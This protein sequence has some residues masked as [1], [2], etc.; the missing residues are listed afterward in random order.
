MLRVIDCCKKT[1]HFVP[2]L[3]PD[4]CTVFLWTTHLFS[5][6]GKISESSICLL[7]PKN[8]EKCYDCVV[9]VFLSTSGFRNINKCRHYSCALDSLKLVADCCVR[10]ACLVYRVAHTF[11]LAVISVIL[12]HTRYATSWSIA[13]VSKFIGYFYCDLRCIC[14][15]VCSN[16]IGMI[17]FI[18]AW[19]WQW[20]ECRFYTTPDAGLD[21]GSCFENWYL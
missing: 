15:S 7:S 16:M 14:C 9:G 11:H 5:S 21:L 3:L 1:L 6:F 19:M 2:V 17:I 18:A 12:S 8:S 4:V 13:V 20:K 10:C